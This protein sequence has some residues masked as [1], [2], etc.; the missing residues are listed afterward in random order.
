MQG[1]Q[2]QHLTQPRCASSMEAGCTIVN[3]ARTQTGRFAREPPDLENHRA[4]PP[5][6]AVAQLTNRWR[7]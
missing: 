3:Y 6:R 4:P 7:A 2:N 5:N 1:K